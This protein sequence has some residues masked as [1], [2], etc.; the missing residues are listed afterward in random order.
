VLAGDLVLALRSNFWSGGLPWPWA[1]ALAEF[2]VMP[3]AWLADMQP[4]RA[5]LERVGWCALALYMVLGYA[6]ARGADGRRLRF[7]IW[8][9][10]FALLPV[11]SSVPESRLL[12]PAMAGYSV[13]LAALA[14]SYVKAVRAAPARLFGWLPLAAAGALVLLHA[15]A[16]PF[17]A[18]SEVEFGARFASAVR[19]SILSPRL[20]PAMRSAQRVLLLGAA[21]PTTSTYIPLVR[22]IHGAPAPRA[23]HLLTATSSPIFL[24]RASDREFVIE[25]LFPGLTPGDTYGAAFNG[26]AIRAGQR[27]AVE[28]MRVTVE[29]VY[30]GRPFETRFVLDRSLDDPAVVLLQ[31]SVHGLAPITFPKVGERVLLPPPIAPFEFGRGEHRGR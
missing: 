30:E 20:D 21:D 7:L 8:G 14:A 18:R 1:S 22:R 24:T 12:A 27:F 15:T 26:G 3:A 23:C 2:G 10:P 17:F 4:L 19:G 29:R 5:L 6:A 31:Q 28:G 16:A 11:V 9:T 25:R 13:V